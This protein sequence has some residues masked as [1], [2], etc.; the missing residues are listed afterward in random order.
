M[1]KTL[2]RC[3]H[4]LLNEVMLCSI[5]ANLILKGSK[6]FPKYNPEAILYQNICVREYF[7]IRSVFE[8]GNSVRLRT[9]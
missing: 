4:V 6:D 3:H 5:E 9:W 1:H 7:R 2:H 8:Y